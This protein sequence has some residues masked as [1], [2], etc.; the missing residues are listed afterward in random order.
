[1]CNILNFLFL[2]IL[3]LVYVISFTDD[4]DSGSPKRLFLFM[5]IDLHVNKKGFKNSSACFKFCFMSQQS[6][7]YIL[8]YITIL[9]YN[10][11]WQH[12]IVSNT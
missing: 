10:Q 3:L 9:L 5:H 4:G 8:L 6:L 11:I 12:G 1:M 2:V 7:Q